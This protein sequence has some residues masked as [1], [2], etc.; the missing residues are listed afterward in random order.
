MA[1]WFMALVR[2]PGFESCS[3]RFSS[4]FSQSRLSSNKTSIIQYNMYCILYYAYNND[5]L[6]LMNITQY[7]QCEMFDLKNCVSTKVYRKCGIQSQEVWNTV[8][9]SVEHSHRK[10]EI[11]S[12]EGWRSASCTLFTSLLLVIIITVKCMTPSVKLHDESDRVTIT[13]LSHDT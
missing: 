11:L 3:C 5:V 13:C 4:S 10:C 6:A 1:Q 8:T 7:Q 9:G 2:N 12:Q